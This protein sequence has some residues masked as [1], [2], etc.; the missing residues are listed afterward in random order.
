MPSHGEFQGQQELRSELYLGFSRRPRHKAA[1]AEI[2]RI[3]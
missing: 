2:R 3:P 1:E